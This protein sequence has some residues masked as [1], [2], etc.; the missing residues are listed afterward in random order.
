MSHIEP[1]TLEHWK[2][3][4]EAQ[5]FLKEQY[6]NDNMQ[7]RRRIYTLTHPTA[8]WKRV[9]FKLLTRLMKRD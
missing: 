2:A 9:G 7:L 4:A 3:I 6:M 5:I 8:R 1:E